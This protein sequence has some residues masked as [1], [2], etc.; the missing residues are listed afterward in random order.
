MC[1]SARTIYTLTHTVQFFFF[2][3]ICLCSVCVR[4]QEFQKHIK[5]KLKCESIGLECTLEL[6]CYCVYFVVNLS[7]FLLIKSILRSFCLY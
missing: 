1:T 5:K 7:V 2:I 3:S 6:G 4:H